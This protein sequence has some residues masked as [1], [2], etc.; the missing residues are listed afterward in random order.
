M[1]QYVYQADPWN[2]RLGF[3]SVEDADGK[4]SKKIF[5]QMVVEKKGDESHSRIHEKK[6]PTKQ[7]QDG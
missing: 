6:S 7:I 2:R 5:S 4:G 3:A 1:I